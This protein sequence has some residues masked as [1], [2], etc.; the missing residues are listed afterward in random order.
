MG[1]RKS[2]FNHSA[3]DYQAE[4]GRAVSGQQFSSR[5]LREYDVKPAVATPP[6]AMRSP[7]MKDTTHPYINVDMTQ[8]HLLPLRASARECGKGHSTVEGLEPRRPD[9]H[10]AEGAKR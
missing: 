5:Y 4:S 3:R 9:T 2:L 7:F 6:Q 1:V 8:W 10:R